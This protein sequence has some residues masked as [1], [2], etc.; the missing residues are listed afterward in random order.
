MA[1]LKSDLELLLEASLTIDRMKRE[2][3]LRKE[4]IAELAKELT[5][6]KAQLQTAD[7]QLAWARRA[8]GREEH[9]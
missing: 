4:A 1:R 2:A 3:D 7:S 9:A 8:L 6:L 5:L